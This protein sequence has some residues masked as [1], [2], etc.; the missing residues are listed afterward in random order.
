MNEHSCQH[1]AEPC[2]RKVPIFAALT[3]EDLS[4]ISAM[5]KHR[6]FAKGQPLIL[7]GEPS[8][9]LHII[10]WGHV[11]L[12]KM[13]PEGKEQILH[14]LTNGDFFGELSIFNSDELSNFSAYA[15]KDTNICMLTRTDMEQLMTENPEISV[16]ILKSVTKRLAHTENLAQ[17]L[18]TKDPEIRIAYM[19]MELS[20]KYGKLRS[21]NIHIALP[22]S[23]EGIANYVGVTRE[24]ISRKF[25]KFEQLGLIKLVGNKKMI[26]L[27]PAG[28]EKIYGG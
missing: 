25:S 2:T 22:L 3:D 7:E 15:L 14:V 1:A 6:K 8:D 23:R 10:Q 18:A 21:G 11:K 26:L 28:M 16:R 9:T 4:R 5:I 13:T 24:T 12:S 17:S 19:I 27:D 20:D